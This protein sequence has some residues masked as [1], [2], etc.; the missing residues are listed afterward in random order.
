MPPPRRKPPTE[1]EFFG[2]FVSEWFGHRVHPV[3]A[4]VA[5]VFDDQRTKR[6]PFLTEAT[7][8]DTECVKSAASKGICTISSTSNGPRQ[9]WLICPN[10]A[11]VQPLL[12]L[13]GA[14]DRHDNDDEFHD[15]V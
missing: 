1:G 4:R 12:K 3:V 8:H 7:G 13:L 14:L 11:L 2:N 10:R 6:C 15:Q 9:D 5:Q